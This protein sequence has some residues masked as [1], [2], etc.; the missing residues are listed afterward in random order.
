MSLVSRLALLVVVAL[1]PLW[2]VQ[3]YNEW[4]LRALR[5]ADVR[6]QALHLAR[7]TAAE[8]ERTVEGIKELLVTLAA[9]PIV[10]D[11]EPAACTAFFA[12]LRRD[13][14]DYLVIGAADRTGRAFCNSTRSDRAPDV[15]DRDYFKRV[16]ATGA[17]SVGVFMESR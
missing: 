16:M 6:D 8:I 10:R 12:K 14:A 1:A 11:E 5:E 7:E 17:F 4:Q 3:Q 13:F 2:A 15:S 9:L